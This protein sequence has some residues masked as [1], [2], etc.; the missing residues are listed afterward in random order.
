MSAYNKS[1]LV[2]HDLK[3]LVLDRDENG[4]VEGEKICFFYRQI[5]CGDLMVIIN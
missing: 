2:L 5:C 3:C 4:M 1:Y